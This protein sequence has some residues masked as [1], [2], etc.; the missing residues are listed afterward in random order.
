MK[1]VGTVGS[2]IMLVMFA[3]IVSVGITAS[4]DL[5]GEASASNDTAVAHSADGATHVITPIF[6]LMGF[7]VLIVGIMVAINA[8]N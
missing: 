5:L 3:L 8:Y 6:Q 4:S 1:T 2:L 7:G